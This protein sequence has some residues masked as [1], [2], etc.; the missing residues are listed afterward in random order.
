MNAKLNGFI[1]NLVFILCISQF[2]KITEATQY[3][4]ETKETDGRF[5]KFE[6]RGSVVKTMNGEIHPLDNEY[7]KIYVPAI[8]TEES[9]ELTKFLESLPQP[10][11]NSRNQ[12]RQQ[13]QNVRNIVR[14]NCS[15]PPVVHLH[16]WQ[17]TI[18]NQGD[19][20]TS[21]A[22]AAVAAL[23]ASYAR[24]RRIESLDLS[25]QF[26][27]W[28]AR[29]TGLSNQSR[30][31]SF[32]GGGN[33]HQVLDALA[34]YSIPDEV[35][36]PYA[37]AAGMNMIKNSISK[38]G[39]LDR[40]YATQKSIDN[41]EAS[42][43]YINNKQKKRAKYGVNEYLKLSQVQARDICTLERI[44]SSYHEVIID[45]QLKW[46]MKNGIMVSSMNNSIINSKSDVGYH[47]LLLVG[48]NRPAGYFI[49]KNSWGGSQYEKISYRLIKSNAVGASFI[50][51]NIHP[52]GKKSYERRLAMGYLGK[53]YTDIDGKRGS[54]IVRRLHPSNNIGHIKSYAPFKQS[55]ILSGSLRNNK[56]EL[57]WKGN[58]IVVVIHKE[59]RSILTGVTKSLAA[60]IRTASS[61]NIPVPHELKMQSEN[62]PESNKKRIQT[63][64]DDE[65]NKNNDDNEDDSYGFNI[66]Q[67]FVAQVQRGVLFSRRAF[68][69]S[70]VPLLSQQT[71]NI[72]NITGLWKIFVDGVHI[73][74]IKLGPY[75]SPNKY[76]EGTRQNVRIKYE[77]NNF[78]SRFAKA[79]IMYGDT[80]GTQGNA[81]QL[82][83]NV[84]QNSE[85]GSEG[86]G[87]VMRIYL[88]FHTLETNIMSGYTRNT[89]GQ[90]IGVY[91]YRQ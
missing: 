19:R 72:N 13:Q 84:M 50:V 56:L 26:T 73:G 14:Y 20:G 85:E 43:Q 41:F 66:D 22:F 36:S 9:S 49:A 58:N 45:L 80:F 46:E 5:D 57:Q 35:D 37:S 62:K 10:R 52:D 39:S 47:T 11:N 25:E 71:F 61:L 42:Q 75:I 53:W 17:T 89:G 74:K 90:V 81:I 59:D 69:S 64:F 1:V 30:I 4:E 15:A 63:D 88:F 27:H 70:P 38:V 91:A 29:S 82:L 21:A 76:A 55:S 6:M 3:G 60:S 65:D 32:W 51:S 44:I 86:A 28:I 7:D 83:L 2:I 24:T 54:A 77:D 40:R 33:S 31:C 87:Q 68:P 8:T 18:K 78:L 48:Y 23:E 79:H 16:K 67:P 12:Q 34:K